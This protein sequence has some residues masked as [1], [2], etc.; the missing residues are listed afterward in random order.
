LF[1]P[2]PKDAGLVSV[3]RASKTSAK[4]AFDLHRSNGHT[5]NAVY[6]VAVRE[7]AKAEVHAYD[8]P[9]PDNPAH[10]YIDMNL[11]SRG[12][13]EAVAGLLRDLAVSRGQIY[14]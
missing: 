1:K 6:A 12:K 7:V 5:T 4:D 9:Q 11:L 14:P 10:A 3:S 13:T 2:T 8:D